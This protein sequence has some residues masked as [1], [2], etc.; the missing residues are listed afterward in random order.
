MRPCTSLPGLTDEGTRKRILSSKPSYT[1]LV[2]VKILHLLTSS[3]ML[4]SA[5][6]CCLQEADVINAPQSFT[7]QLQAPPLAFGCSVPVEFSGNVCP[8]IGRIPY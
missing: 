6:S 1:V 5:T 3:L 4:L 2:T 8:E 7:L